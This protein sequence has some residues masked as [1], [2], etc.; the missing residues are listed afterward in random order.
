M[1]DPADISLVLRGTLVSPRPDRSLAIREHGVV[2]ARPGPACSTTLSLTLKT[3]SL[4]S[5]YAVVDK[6]GFITAI[7]DRT[8]TLADEV[9]SLVREGK[10]GEDQVVDLGD[11]WVLPGFVDTHSECSNSSRRRPRLT[12][13]G[14]STLLN[15][16][17][18]EWLST[19]H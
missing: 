18:L 7:D 13:L 11:G 9:D 14:Q 15:I 3:L 6:K 16:Q 17:T 4:G 19:S 8:S 1:L 2:G 5:R 12:L 10:V